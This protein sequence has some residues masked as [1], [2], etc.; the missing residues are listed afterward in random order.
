MR[1]R[2]LE[3]VLIERDAGLS[4]PEAES[5]AQSIEVVDGHLMPER[6]NAPNSLNCGGEWTQRNGSSVGN[7]Q[8]TGSSSGPL[9][10]PTGRMRRLLTSRPLITHLAS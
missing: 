5:P 2:V 10:A 7:T 3:V 1:R 9:L 6:G 4:A 8:R